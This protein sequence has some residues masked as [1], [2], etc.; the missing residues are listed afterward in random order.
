MTLS[1]AKYTLL[2]LVSI[3]F[4]CGCTSMNRGNQQ[5]SIHEKLA[6]L[7]AS[8]QG[9][10]GAIAINM[11]NND[12]IGYRADEKFP[13]CSTFKVMAVSAVL[14]KSMS[15]SN[16]L[17]Q[18]IFY[19]RDDVTKADYSPITEKH[20]HDGMTVS[21]LCSA[22]IQYSDN[23]AVNLL[24]K[25][26]GGPEAVTSFSRSMGD[27]TFRLDRWEP[28]LNSAIPGDPRDTTSP[29]AMAKSLQQLL[30]GNTLGLQQR[31]QLKIWLKGNTTGDARIRA[32]VPKG[33]VVGDKTGTCSYGTA[34]DVGII[35]PS[36][37]DPIIIAIYFTQKEKDATPRNDIIASVTQILTS[38]LH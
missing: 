9:R 16:F 23:T 30:F 8:S 36:T 24:M 4:A 25:K 5:N 3:V 2:A 38:N 13:F 37:G 28:E 26:L 1:Q 27:S 11:T 31:E 12:R 32:G 19:T 15:D 35:W 6:E 10:I 21:E 17:E 33:W 22:A 20:I 29:A 18:R 7:E 14:K 34:N